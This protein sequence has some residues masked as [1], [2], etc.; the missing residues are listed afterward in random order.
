VLTWPTFSDAADESG[1]SR[2]YLGVHFRDADIEGRLLGRRV[3]AVSGNKAQE[4][5][6]EAETAKA[7]F[8]F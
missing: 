3:A 5:I 1:M 8:D 4:Y 2:R 7:A 6:S